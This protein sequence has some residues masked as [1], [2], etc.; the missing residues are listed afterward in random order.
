MISK[1]KCFYLH[2][3]NISKQSLVQS[4]GKAVTISFVL[5][6]LQATSTSVSFAAQAVGEAVRI[7]NKVTAS[8]GNRKLSKSD[9][10]FAKEK[11]RASK[12]SNGQL[13]LKD[14]SKVIVGENSSVSLDN[15]VFSNGSIAKGTFKVT[16]GALRL[17]SGN[18]PKGRYKIKT[19]VATI[20]V[21]GTAL[22]VFVRKSGETDIIL[23]N[24]TIQTC[25][26]ASCITSRRVC[27]VINIK[28]S[29]AIRK[30]PN[31]RYKADQKGDEDTR[32]SAMWPQG[33]YVKTHQVRE[34][35]CKA[36][37]ANDIN[38]RK[39]EY[40]RLHEEDDDEIITKP[41]KPDVSDTST[42]T[43]PFC[44]ETD[45]GCL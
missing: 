34:W 38:N 7:K 1:N 9:Q 6:A 20:G 15:F 19:P 24:G 14:N 17:I 22:D 23:Y 16:K 3:V 31:F 35:V 42:P 13:V 11:I 44:I 27:D 33:G 45:T 8:K 4:I 39:I 2:H 37:A 43:Y 5:L 36:R 32:Y 12:K 40:L 29:G 25:S 10:V 28:P 41:T 18:G 30:L 26:S 21:R